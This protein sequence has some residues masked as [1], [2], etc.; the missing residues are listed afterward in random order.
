M[1]I[2]SYELILGRMLSRVPSGI[3][4]REGSVIY[5]ALAPCAMELMMMYIELEN[6]LTETFADTASR[7]YL[8]RRA[9][10]RG[11]SPESS[12]HAILKAVSTP[13]DLELKPGLRF[14]L[15]DLN[16]VLEGCIAKGEYKLK[17]ETPGSIGNKY[18]GPLVPIDYVKG[19]ESI[20]L[21]EL[22]I[23][24]EDEE[25]TE[26]FRER[27]LSSFGHKAYGGNVQDYKD[28]TNSIAGV[29]A[30]KVTP[31]HNG[32]GTVKLTILDSEFG[33]ASDVLID[34]VQE[35]IDPTLDGHGVGIAP[36]GHVVTVDTATEVKIDIEGE[37]ILSG[38]QSLG[39]VLT[40]IRDSVGDYLLALRKNWDKSTPVIR[41]AQIESRILGIDGVLDIIGTKINGSKDNF[42][43]GEYEIPILGEVTHV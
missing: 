42:S 37:F 31:V 17:C 1:E 29:G 8:I 39:G 5:D 18:F 22:L 36:I 38:E 14:S 27:Y 9:K 16:Y 35:I 32:G 26:V 21:T 6:V 23:P 34:T 12:T 19:L 7:E 41:V 2:M 3:D 11:L 30:T 33:R 10:E 13:P 4:K 25:D 24:G 15:E 28:K 43:L 20:E 40:S